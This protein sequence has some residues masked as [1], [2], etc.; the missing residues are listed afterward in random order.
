[1]SKC[2][3]I[4]HFVFINLD[5]FLCQ[6]YESACWSSLS[7]LH[8]LDCLSFLFEN[9][10]GVALCT[11]FKFFWDR[12]RY[13]SGA[14]PSSYLCN[15]GTGLKILSLSSKLTES[16]FFGGLMT[17]LC[18]WENNIGKVLYVAIDHNIKYSVQEC[19]FNHVVYM[20]KHMLAQPYHQAFLLKGSI[21]IFWFST[22]STL[23]QVCLC[24]QCL[25]SVYVHTLSHY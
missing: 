24:H 6:F 1:M 5:L 11:G 20:F 25:P 16:S 8:C 15:C 23:R 21:V 13:T 10:L 18:Q 7:S 22:T 4:Q 12:T 17:Q 14:S 2:N 9:E 3:I 19:F